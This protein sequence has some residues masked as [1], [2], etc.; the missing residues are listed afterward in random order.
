MLHPVVV[1]IVNIFSN[2]REM[3]EHIL[4]VMFICQNKLVAFNIY[5]IWAEV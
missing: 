1:C 3:L 2:T 4:L 5:L